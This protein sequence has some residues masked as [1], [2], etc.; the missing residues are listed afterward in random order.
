MYGKNFNYLN[1]KSKIKPLKKADYKISRV[2][3]E[4]EYSIFKLDLNSLK[5]YQIHEKNYLII[6][7]ISDD[8]TKSYFIKYNNFKI[9]KDLSKTFFICFQ[10]KKKSIKLIKIGNNKK[11][12]NLNYK[13]INVKKKKKYWGYIST[14]FENHKGSIKLIKM[15]QDKQSSMEFH[16]NKKESYFIISGKLRLGIRYSRAKQRSL[17]LLK[18]NSFMMQPGTM[19]MRMA[20]KNTIILEMSTKDEDNDSIIVEDGLKYKFHEIR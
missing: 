18:N 4:N 3:C 15:L 2:F 10:D 9:S 11:I 1:T 7:N 6:F 5:K 17:Y 16:I 8:Y 20:V 13:N 14:L 19:H 12:K